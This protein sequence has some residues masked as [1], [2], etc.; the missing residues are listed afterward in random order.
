M[1]LRDAA[2]PARAARSAAPRAARRPPPHQG[3]HPG[4][5]LLEPERLGQV[6]V[7]AR[8][9]AADDV[10]DRVAGGEHQ[11]GSVAP[12]ATE[13]RRHLESVLLGQHD[14]EQDDV[15]LVDVG[16][17]GGFVAVRRDVH[18]LALFLQTLLDEPGDLPVVLHDENFHGPEFMRRE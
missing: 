2:G 17:H 11:D 8:I 16:Q 14:V 9:E 12:L 1:G 7:R 13:L 4:Q 5:E 6:V 15:V 10:F 3:P 18:G